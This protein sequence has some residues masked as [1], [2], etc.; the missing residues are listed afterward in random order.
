M[1]NAYGFTKS[2]AQHILKRSRSSQ[3]ARPQP[4]RD[5]EPL[6]SAAI[7]KVKTGGLTARSGTTLGSG[8]VTVQQIASGSTI[9]ATSLDVTVYNLG[10]TA[11]AVDEY[12]SIVQEFV[13]GKWFATQIS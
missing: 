3:P 2:D 4:L 6:A 9:S 7:G 13:T 10:T 11:I 5:A 1:L 8:T 12:V